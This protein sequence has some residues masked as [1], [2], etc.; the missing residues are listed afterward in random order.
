[1]LA[2]NTF[3]LSLTVL[4]L[5]TEI[6]SNDRQTITIRRL[7]ALEL[8]RNTMLNDASFNLE[9]FE[10]CQN[11]TS[12]DRSTI[13]VIPLEWRGIIGLVFEFDPRF[14]GASAK[15]LRLTLESHRFNTEMASL[16]QQ[17]SQQC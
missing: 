15:K 13:D 16:S 9:Q 4:E 1:M 14:A 3:S 6:C 17:G 8:C 2:R 7:L 10:S 12:F 11:F 5:W